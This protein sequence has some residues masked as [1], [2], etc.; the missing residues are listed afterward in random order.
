MDFLEDIDPTVLTLVQQS[1]Q[2]QQHQTK[3]KQPKPPTPLPEQRREH[4]HCHHIHQIQSPVILQPSSAAAAAAASSSFTSWTDTTTTTT[5]TLD[6][7]ETTR[8]MYG[9]EVTT[10]TDDCHFIPLQHDHSLRSSSSLPFLS[11]SIQRGQQYYCKGIRAAQEGNWNKALRYWFDALEVRHQLQSSTTTAM[12][13]QMDIADTYHNIGIAYRKLE[14]YDTALSYLDVAL[15]MRMDAVTN[16]G[17]DVADAIKSND[18]NDNP[19]T[20]HVPTTM[21][22][23]DRLQQQ[24]QQQMLHMNIASS[25]RTIGNIYQKQNQLS[26]AIQFYIK[27]KLVQE[28]LIPTSTTLIDMARTC[29]VIGHTYAMGQVYSDAY[30]AYHDAVMIFQQLWNR[31]TYYYDNHNYDNDDSNHYEQL[32]H[33]EYQMT[34]FN[35]RL[36]EQK[37]SSCLS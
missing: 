32:Y 4:H 5:T 24:Q 31:N 1:L 33:S 23:Q 3:Q 16:N 10:T 22:Q 14:Q 30:E 25:L 34:L 19:V 37:Q 21:P 15:E 13:F 2:Q 20:D 8:S 17:V 36:M 6:W 28:Q 18:D 7:N 11:Q 27:C 26:L 29:N 12:P 35:L 9:N